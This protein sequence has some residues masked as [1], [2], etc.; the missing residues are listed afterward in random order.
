MLGLGKVAKNYIERYVK[1]QMG[2]SPDAKKIKRMSNELRM[3]GIAIAGLK[4]DIAKLSKMAHS[5]RNLVE[6]NGKYYLEEENG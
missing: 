3:Q 2:I 4:A 6:R 1:Q 5:R